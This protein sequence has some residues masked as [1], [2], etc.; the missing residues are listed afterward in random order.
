VT[1]QTGEALDRALLRT[2][3]TAFPTGE[4]VGQESF[5]TAG[6]VL[7]LAGRAGVAPGVSVLDL[8]C[9]AA[10]AGLFVT[11]EL[12][13]TYLGVDA[14]PVA[15]ARARQRATDDG[16]EARFGVAQV[17][18]VPSGSFDVVL[19][20]E[21]ML[22][23]RDKEAL[24]HGISA[25]LPMGG[26]L[27]FTLEEGRPLSR[28]ERVMMPRSDTVWLVPWS[29]LLRH[30]A[31][32]GLAVRWHAEW[33]GAH[34]ATVDALLDAYAASARGLAAVGGDDTVGALLCAHRLWSRWLRE[35][36]V[37]KLAV[38]AEKVRR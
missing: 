32:A 11:R 17:P 24:L 25:A 10:G 23:F 5:V 7:S 26:R 9:G 37:R 1:T 35:G 14:D 6:E 21:T 20:L 34:L 18:P 22:A 13:C 12:G 3:A 36:R 29:D 16:L 19:L 8:C 30:L 15:V 2:R 4:F 28:T 38:V 33:T 27:A 31:R